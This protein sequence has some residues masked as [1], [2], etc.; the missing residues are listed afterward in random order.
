MR[1]IIIDLQKSGTWKGQLTI[2]INLI[3]SK[4]FYI[5][6]RCVLLEKHIILLMIQVEEKEVCFCLAVKQLSVLL[7]AINSKHRVVF[8][9]WI[10]FIQKTNL[11]LMKKYVKI[12]I[13]VE[14]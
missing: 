9:L 12:K 4:V 1:D 11:S 13:L 2:A 5:K 3:S 6:E 7:H 14:F 10:A 8:V